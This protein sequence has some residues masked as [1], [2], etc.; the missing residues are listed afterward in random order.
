MRQFLCTSLAIAAIAAFAI[1][2]PSTSSNAAAP[3][4]GQPAPDFEAADIDGNTFKLSDHKGKI[5]VLEWSN[6]ECPFVVKHYGSGNM[7]K[8]QKET[9]EKGVEWVTIVSSAEGRQ[10]NVSNEKAKEI[11]EE[12][13]ATVSAK[14]LDASGEIGKLYD[15]KTTPHMFVI[16]TEG[17]LAYEGAIDN[18]ASPNPATIEGAENY[19][20][21]AVDAL[22]AGEEI[23]TAQTKPYGCSVKYAY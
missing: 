12:T 7:Q 1:M 17:N 19:V 10:G 18:N 22:L 16:D 20:T 15:A 23:T 11:L 8:T 2:S 13:G 9:V 14:I 5:V 6:H 3:E 4:I 21:A